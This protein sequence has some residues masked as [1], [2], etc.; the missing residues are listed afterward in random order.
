MLLEA[1]PL[2]DKILKM[3]G[4]AGGLVCLGDGRIDAYRPPRGFGLD[5]GGVSFARV[6][7]RGS[8]KTMCEGSTSRGLGFGLVST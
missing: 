6:S 3:K 8:V 1:E 2:F 5:D 4:Y 7:E